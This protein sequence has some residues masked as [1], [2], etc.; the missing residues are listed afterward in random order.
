[1]MSC[2]YDD[3]RL[4]IINQK[5]HSVCLETASDTLLQ[6]NAFSNQEYS[7]SDQEYFLKKEVTPGDIIILHYMGQGGWPGR[8]QHNKNQ[9]LNLFVYHSD[10]VR[11]H[12]Y[13]FDALEG[14]ELEK[15]SLSLE[16]LEA[17]NWH[18]IVK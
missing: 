7:L 18:V 8:V 1:M 17:R 14:R 10:S 13:N 16:E 12:D 6:Y 11:K 4:M 15:I 3:N 5:N 2:S 9:K